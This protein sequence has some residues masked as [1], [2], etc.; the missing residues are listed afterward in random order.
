MPINIK[1]PHVDDQNTNFAFDM[2]K[3]T[4]DALRSN[5]ILLL[6][7][8]KNERYYMPD[9]G[10]DLN[11]LIFDQRDDTTLKL[12]EENI[13]TSVEKYI[14][15]LIIKS[16]DFF[17]VEEVNDGSIKEN[18]IDIEIVFNYTNDAFSP[19]QSVVLTKTI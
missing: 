14:P 10:S 12:I 9:Y 4:K 13:K 16:V 6:S 17:T 11:K 19:N 7:T 3:T 5:L 8:N 2:S 1:F 15:Q 18:Q